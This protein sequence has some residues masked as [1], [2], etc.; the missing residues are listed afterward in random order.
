MD[1]A[2]RACRRLTRRLA[3]P[4]H[5]VL[6]LGVGL[7][8]VLAAASPGDPAPPGVARDRRPSLGGPEPWDD[9]HGLAT[10]SITLRPRL[11]PTAGV[12]VIYELTGRPVQ[13]VRSLAMTPS[14]AATRGLE[15]IR[16]LLVR[17]ER[18]IVDV[19]AEPQAGRIRLARPLVGRRLRVSYLAEAAP[20][21]SRLDLQ[22]RPDELSGIG[23]GFLALPEIDRRLAVRLRWALDAVDTPTAATSF[24]TGTDVVSVKKPLELAH[25]F[26]LA[27]S[28]QRAE[29]EH[30]ERLIVLGTPAFDLEPA[31]AFCSA[32]LAGA[33]RLF[34][35]TDG[36]PFSFIFVPQRGLASHYDGAA[37]H[38]GFVVWFD[39]ARPLDGRLRLLAAHEIVH[40]W[41]GGALRFVDGD[42]DDATWFSEGF[43]VHFART[44]LWREGLLTPKEFLADLGRDLAAQ[45]RAFAARR[46]GADHGAEQVIH[47]ATPAYYRGALY[48]AR[49]DGLLRESGRG[50]LEHLLGDLLTR[51]RTEGPALAQAAWRRALTAALGPTADVE[52]DRLVRLADEPIDLPS[53]SLGPCFERVPA[54]QLVYDLGFSPRSLDANPPVVQE[55]VPDSAAARAGLR[56]GQRI[57]AGVETIRPHDPRRPVALVVADEQPP[58]LVRYLPAQVAERGAWRLADEAACRVVPARP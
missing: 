17:D 5:V 11:E 31:L 8:A 18:G 26:F 28:I 36:Q 24:G 43:T 3:A 27:G 48:A 9:G 20:A 46:R 32:A 53:G 1:R 45:E 41:I 44:V 30:G 49:L 10:L 37:L 33:R 7:L 13:A 47:H 34:E 4:A 23:Y 42:G 51:A 15:A 21:P 40:R 52:F 55:L 16:Y 38:D 2:I 29:G 6:L 54:R 25:S 19:D 22:V 12:A 56:E 57:V 35:P 50:S 58:R 14:T 39:A